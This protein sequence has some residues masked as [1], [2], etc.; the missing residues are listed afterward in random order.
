MNTQFLI[1][2]LNVYYG[3]KLLALKAANNN[4]IS[5]QVATDFTY[6]GYTVVETN[7]REPIEGGGSSQELTHMNSGSGMSGS[8]DVSNCPDLMVL[9]VH[10]N[11]LTDKNIILYNTNL[12]LLDIRNN[13]FG[14][15][16][17]GSGTQAIN[18][19]NNSKLCTLVMSN[20]G[21]RIGI[22]DS[23]TLKGNSKY[24]WQAS[25]INGEVN[26]NG[27]INH[28]TGVSW[29]V[30][31]KMSHNPYTNETGRGTGRHQTSLPANCTWS[32]MGN[33][34][35]MTGL[36]LSGNPM[37]SIVHLDDTNLAGVAAA[38]GREHGTIDFTYQVNSLKEITIANNGLT[39]SFGP[40]PTD[41][42]YIPTHAWYN[43][44][45]GSG[46]FASASHNVPGKIY[47]G[48][49]TKWTQ[50]ASPG[51]PHAVHGLG[52]DFE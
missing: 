15:G 29:P 44:G 5:Y 1:V 10:G 3:N 7:F 52:N 32:S 27:N 23:Q 26:S 14:M 42:I 41:D 48:N 38:G 51:E 21:N 45:S 33:D 40:N 6:D 49:S 2:K 47:L 20:G 13:D 4:H 18:L 17:T 28:N 37:L 39:G 22:Q 31:S 34:L 35:K 25:T 8:L 9:D 36:D 11:A 46:V 19:T 50:S 43:E 30:N 24:V 16:V 12:R